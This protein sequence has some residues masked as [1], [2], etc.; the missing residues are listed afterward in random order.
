[1]SAKVRGLKRVWPVVRRAVRS[2]PEQPQDPA[3]EPE[4][5][6][7]PA[8]AEPTLATRVATQSTNPPEEAKRAIRLKEFPKS[9]EITYT[10]PEWYL[11]SCN[12]SLVKQPYKLATD[13]N[14]FILPEPVSKPG[15]PAVIF[16]GDSVVEN[17]YAHPETRVCSRLQ[18]IL[19][20]EEGVHVAVLNAGYSGATVLHSFN[21]FMNK[22][23]PL[24]PAAVVLMTGI[25]D[26]Y[27]SVVKDSFWCRDCWMEP[28]IDLGQT[29][30]DRD[31]D[32]RSDRS[33]DDQRRLMTMFAV[34]G[35][36]FDVS[37]WY[38]TVPHRQVFEGEWVRKVFKSRDDF[39]HAAS[40][41]EAVN[42]VT[43]R[44]AIEEGVPLF[45]VEADLAHRTDIF[46]DMFHLN[47]DGGDAVARSLIKCGFVD[48]LRLV[49]V[50]AV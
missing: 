41:R 37:V 42:D 9:T 36:I 23:I 48:K 27:V 46:Y 45:D 8:G 7:N 21:T 50:G 4:R 38:A 30:P 10:P 25:C 35:R 14:G 22:I 44:V 47:A 49:G 3:N 15:S 34:A 13:E 18:D 40:A 17:K 32:Q 6:A 1:M 33:F 26:A 24:R 2:F 31:P 43:R 39:N 5:L 11:A 12:A 16:L 20:N 29:K 19:G 28:I